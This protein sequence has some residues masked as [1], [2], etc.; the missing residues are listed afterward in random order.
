VDGAQKL[1]HLRIEGRA[2]SELFRSPRPARGP[3]YPSPPRD[4]LPHGQ[5]LIDQLEDAEARAKA[6]HAAV[7]ATPTGIVL[8]FKSDPTSVLAVKSLEAAKH[9]I[10]LLNTRLE[11]DV[12]LAAVFIPNGKLIYFKNKFSQYLTEETDSGAF[13]HKP[14]VESIAQIR[15]EAVKAYW[16]DIGIDFPPSDKRVVWEVWLRIGQDSDPTLNIFRAEAEHRGMQPGK[17]VIRFPD[18][19]VILA[20]GTADQIRSSW[21]MLDMIA[22]LRLAKECPTSYVDLEPF[23]QAEYAKLALDRLTAPAADA[24]AVCILDTGVNHGH[25]LLSPALNGEHSLTCFPA[26]TAADKIGHG[27]QM[28]G[29]ALY[30]DLGPVLDGKGPIDLEHRL[31]AV[32]IHPESDLPHADLFGAVCYEAAT[33]IETVCPNRQRVFCMAV[34]ANDNRDQGL[35]TSWSGKLDEISYGGPGSP[36]RLFFVAAGN[37]EKSARRDYPASNHTA[38]LHDPGQAWNIVTVGALTELAVIKTDAYADWMPIAMPGLLSPSSTTSLVWRGE[39][40][41]KPDIVLE[42]GNTALHPTFNQPEM[43]E[44]LLM[45][46]TSNKPAKG[47]FAPTGQ[48]SAATALASRMAARIQT[49]YPDYWPETVRGLMIHSAEWTPAMLKEYR[50]RNKTTIQNRMRCYGYGAPDLDRALWC[51]R[52]SLSLISQAELQPYDMFETVNDQ[53]RKEKK[54]KTKD[55]HIYDLPW[56]VAELQSLGEMMVTLRVTLSYFI[57]PSPGRRGWMNRHRYASHGLRFEMMRPLDTPEMFRKRMNKMA[58]EEE[59]GSPGGGDTNSWTLGSKL[60]SRGSIHS[61]YW[62]GMATSLADCKQIG[63]FPVTGWWRERQQLGRWARKVRYS[64]IVSITTPPTAVDIYNPV[65]IQLGI[66]IPIEIADEP[67]S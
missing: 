38:S 36:Q 20:E 61:D 42:G 28:A 1:P 24:V 15:Y 26:S 17:R 12:Q 21:I 45:L 63:I 3:T 65:R 2:K 8:V 55:M 56:P 30:G 5:G 60:R 57:E 34:T 46:S 51:G 44:D 41:L 6:E 54:V 13:K 14:F 9:G 11:D 50:G 40:P 27:T 52:N 4:R 62:N 7:E 19:A 32:K 59:E 43:I 67:E 33:M 22:E 31:E 18:R 49:A 58:R 29:L 10:E 53:G 66:P 39:W 47:V 25:M 35:P 48:T 16:T 37:T 64:L 23:E